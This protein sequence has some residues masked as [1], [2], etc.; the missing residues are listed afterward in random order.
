MCII[1][2]PM[3]PHWGAASQALARTQAFIWFRK[4][5][6]PLSCVS[7]THEV[8]Q[9]GM[10]ALLRRWQRLTLHQNH[11]HMQTSLNLNSLIADKREENKK[12][13]RLRRRKQ[14]NNI[15]EVVK[16]ICRRKYTFLCGYL[17]LQQE[18]WMSGSF[19]RWMWA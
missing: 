9:Y 4:L 3:H 19:I 1:S 12:R 6:L 10:S 2:F 5:P 14:R 11:L 17:E 16:H 13:G 8:S 18:Y 15:F 7:S